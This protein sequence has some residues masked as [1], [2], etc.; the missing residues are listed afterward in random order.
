MLRIALIVSLL[1][2]LAA[3]T[4]NSSPQQPVK[5]K[6]A[7]AEGTKAT[8][9]SKPPALHFDGLYT[10]GVKAPGTGEPMTSC[11]RF[12][13]DGNMNY[14]V[15]TSKPQEVA[16]LWYTMSKGNPE[17]RYQITG[18]KIEIVEAYGTHHEGMLIGTRLQVVSQESQH[19]AGVY[20]FVPVQFVEVEPANPELAQAP[21]KAGDKNRPPGSTV[22][23]PASEAPVAPAPGRFQGAWEGTTSQ[24][25]GITFTVEGDKITRLR[26]SYSL[27]SRGCFIV[28][29]VSGA[30]EWDWST[31][32]LGPRTSA[33]GFAVHND[34]TSGGMN[35]API[36]HLYAEFRP[37]GT[38]RGGGSLTMVELGPPLC[39]TMEDLT[40]TAHKVGEKS[41]GSD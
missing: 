19:L 15:S 22:T 28:P 32:R 21:S 13:E 38:I 16:R 24:D 6:T 9:S 17:A 35:S 36:M 10:A 34:R 39:Q 41:T 14:V 1:G 8:P 7:K 37:D 31:A 18:D 5:Q 40:F 11:L 12:R 20:R 3:T 29:V 27:P 2:L 4:L 23:K 30:T 25:Q 33:T 26:I